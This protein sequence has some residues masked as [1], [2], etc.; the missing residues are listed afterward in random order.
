MMLFTAM[1][2][3]YLHERYFGRPSCPQC[4]ELCTIPEFSQYQSDGQISHVWLCDVCDHEFRTA[5]RFAAS[6]RPYL[7]A[8]A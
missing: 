7:G 3:R 1:P 4:G 2:M 6:D 5:V 8:A